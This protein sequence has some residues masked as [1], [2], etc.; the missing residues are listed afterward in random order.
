MNQQSLHCNATHSNLL[1]STPDG[2][3]RTQIMERNVKKAC[4]KPA[5]MLILCV[6]SF[7]V[8]F[9]DTG[10]VQVLLSLFHEPR[11]FYFGALLTPSLS[12][13]NWMFIIHFHPYCP[14]CHG[15]SHFAS[16]SPVILQLF[17]TNSC[18][19]SFW[20]NMYRKIYSD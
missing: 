17:I 19:I 10:T 8:F 9:C 16:L 18:N 4:R 1:E 3:F 11:N 14:R 15:Y 12:C 13:E 20:L 6:S 7:I 5:H 2:V